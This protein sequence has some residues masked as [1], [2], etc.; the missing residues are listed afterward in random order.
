V[1]NAPSDASPPVQSN[2]SSSASTQD[3][4]SD[5]GRRY[6][7]WWELGLRT[8]YRASVTDGIY[9]CWH[10]PHESTAAAA[11]SVEVGDA[12]S[13]SAAP[14]VTGPPLTVSYLSSPSAL[15]WWPTSHLPFLAPPKSAASTGGLVGLL[16]V[17]RRHRPLVDRPPEDFFRSTPQLTPVLHMMGHMEEQ[18]DEW[19]TQPPQQQHQQ[20]A[21]SQPTAAPSSSSSSSASTF[22]S[23]TIDSVSISPSPSTS[24]SASASAASPTLLCLS[25]GAVLPSYQNRGLLRD[26]LL[27]AIFRQLSA[28]SSS[29]VDSID[30]L[31]GVCSNADSARGLQTIGFRCIQRVEYETFES[32][33]RSGQF[34]FRAQRIQQSIQPEQQRADDA[35]IAAD[36]STV[37]SAAAAS[38]TRHTN[39]SLWVCDTTTF[40]EKW[41]HRWQL[42]VDSA[43]TV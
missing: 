31:Y 6:R 14:A 35:A 20:R 1:S 5:F 43:A 40:R 30:Y 2:P 23:P 9:G 3:S 11:D 36:S 28:A 33:K 41:G 4:S 13:S 38:V 12:S 18:L 10:R 24:T 7:A 22:A 39:C 21:S 15:D 27:Y 8:V 34:P 25:F 29:A 42:D 16:L 32:P 17:E 37:A 19:L 26:L